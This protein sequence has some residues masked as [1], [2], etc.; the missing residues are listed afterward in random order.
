M[1]ELNSEYKYTSTQNF[2]ID[3]EMIGDKA[4]LFM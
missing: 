3:D 4:T 1:D 2:F